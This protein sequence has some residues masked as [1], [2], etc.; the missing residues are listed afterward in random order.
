MIPQRTKQRT[1][2]SFSDGSESTKEQKA[3]LC[4]T[5]RGRIHVLGR[6]CVL[7]GNYSIK[8]LNHLLLNS[9]ER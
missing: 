7:A 3:I 6:V 5:E 2:A 4:P 8:R 1:L 9:F